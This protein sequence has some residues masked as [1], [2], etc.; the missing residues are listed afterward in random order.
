MF[1]P[2]GGSVVM[3]EITAAAFHVDGRIVRRVLAILELA[4]AADVKMSKVFLFSNLIGP[5]FE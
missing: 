2:R 1:G 3:L 5:L 4:I